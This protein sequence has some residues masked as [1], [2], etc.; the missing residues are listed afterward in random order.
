LPLVEVA[1]LTVTPSPETVTWANVAPLKI[2]IA[3]DTPV[4]QLILRTLVTKMGHSV[5][6][7]GNGRL[8]YEAVQRS[9]F[10]MVLMD[11]QMPEMDAL[12]ATA[13]IRKLP[14][15]AD[16]P[17]IA[18]T[19]NAFEEDRERCLA[20]GMNDHVAKPIRLEEL[21]RAIGRWAPAAV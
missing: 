5:E 16:L 18:V 7:V 13:A 11:W 3:E 10:D 9:A 17:I 12:E 4:N 20:A 15:C 21:Q 2:L 14:G 6:V 1:A 8:A 19:A